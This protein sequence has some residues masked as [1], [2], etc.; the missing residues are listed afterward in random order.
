MYVGFVYADDFARK[1]RVSY[2]QGN[3]YRCGCCRRTH[4]VTRDFHTEVE[5]KAFIAELERMQRNPTEEEKQQ[6]DDDVCDFK[7]TRIIDEEAV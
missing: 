4:K 6:D 1:F 2:V 3:G 5:A 7:L